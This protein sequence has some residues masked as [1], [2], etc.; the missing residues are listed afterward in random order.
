MATYAARKADSSDEE[1]GLDCFEV[2]CFRD[3]GGSD[4]VN[5]MTNFVQVQLTAVLMLFAE[6]VEPLRALEAKE[7]LLLAAEMLHSCH[8]L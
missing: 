3:Q 1:S 7:S 5:S 2:D 4:S 8:L 6:H